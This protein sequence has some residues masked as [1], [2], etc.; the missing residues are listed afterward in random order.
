M[1]SRLK[2]RTLLGLW[3]VGFFF[4][5]ACAPA[6]TPTLVPTSTPIPTA[7]A[8]ASATAAP[9]NTPEPTATRTLTPTNTATPTTTNTPTKTL[10]PSVTPTKVG[11]I[12]MVNLDEQFQGYS[13]FVGTARVY[14][15]ERISRKLQF[16]GKTYTFC[17][18]KDY[19][20]DYPDGLDI[21]VAF[22]NTMPNPTQLQDDKGEQLKLASSKVEGIIFWRKPDGS[23][24]V[25]NPSF[26]S[27]FNGV[28]IV[29][30]MQWAGGENRHRIDGWQIWLVNKETR[31]VV[32]KIEHPFI[33]LQSGETIAFDRTS[34]YFQVVRR[35]G[36]VLAPTGMTIGIQMTKP[37]SPIATVEGIPFYGNFTSSDID[38]FRTI[39]AW[40]KDKSPKWWQFVAESKPIILLFDG[41]RQGA[42][43]GG[44]CDSLLRGRVT[45]ANH[46]ESIAD[47]YNQLLTV[48]LIVHE[49]THVRDWRA[50]HFKHST[51]YGTKSDCQINEGSAVKQQ[52]AFL[53]D[54]IPLFPQYN[55]QPS[56]DENNKYAIDVPLCGKL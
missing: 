4:I 41:N 23:F 13:A 36:D 42:W 8:L 10:T 2:I 1:F 32:K 30:V 56:I 26:P 43:T 37:I 3:S 11:E 25:M 44:C 53:T 48:S 55:I 47:E 20:G 31:E 33:N 21:N 27:R 24:V 34:G 54:M 38:T 7:V 6:P 52:N 45:V 22:M 40:L 35:S 17:A 14:C 9:T 5:A 12:E 49:V 50:G 46:F 18:N 15:S 16:D 28:D 29:P 19:Y 39:F 51:P